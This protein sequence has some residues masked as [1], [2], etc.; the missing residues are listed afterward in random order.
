MGKW[1]VA[2]G[3]EVER[4]RGPLPKRMR[5]GMREGT[6]ATRALRL[7]TAP[8]HWPST[9]LSIDRPQGGELGA[10]IKVSIALMP[11]RLRQ[12]ISAAGAASTRCGHR[13]KRASSAHLASMRAS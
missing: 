10:T 8:R 4:G 2:V 13:L 9:G 1:G 6:A 11:G 7:A 3:L 12:R 5:I